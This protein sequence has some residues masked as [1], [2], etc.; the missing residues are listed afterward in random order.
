M[1]TLAAVSA[2][3]TPD[4]ASLPAP[5]EGAA[6]AR[7][8][9]RFGKL[10]LY[11]VENRGQLDP[12]VAYSVH[13]RDTAIYFAKEGITF[14]LI[15]AE[16]GESPSGRLSRASFGKEPFTQRA[17]HRRWNVKLDFLD[18]NPHVQVL[19]TERTEAVVSYFKGSR[20]EWK[21]GLP[22]YSSVLYREL[23]PGIDLLYSGTVDRLKYQFVVR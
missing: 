17:P 15:R 4:R 1:L 8:E 18:A 20:E 16:E 12:R 6:R 3:T 19:G 21:T 22:T 14:S 23:W 11:F 7:L 9:E 5:R 2:P 10:P 13:G